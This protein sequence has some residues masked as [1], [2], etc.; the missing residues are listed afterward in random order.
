MQRFNELKASGTNIESYINMGVSGMQI[1]S[2]AVV[3]TRPA[4]HQNRQ[5]QPASH[6]SRIN[7]S[8]GRAQIPKAVNPAPLVNTGA[9][10]TL[11]S[12]R[13]MKK[14]LTGDDIFSNAVGVKPLI[15]NARQV[16]Y[17]PNFE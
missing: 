8:Q 1:G 16:Y 9:A 4:S 17:Q 2:S 10:I 12:N 15:V 7:N 14:P 11:G 13:L 3:V 5:S 6:Y